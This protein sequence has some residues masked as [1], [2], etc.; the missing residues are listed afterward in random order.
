MITL[1]EWILKQKP[2]DELIIQ[3][4]STDGHDRW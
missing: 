4:S 3:A 2:I 1:R